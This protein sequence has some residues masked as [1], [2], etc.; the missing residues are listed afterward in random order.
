M[1]T[2]NMVLPPLLMA[3]SSSRVGYAQHSTINRYEETTTPQL[4]ELLALHQSL[5]EIPSISGY[6]GEVGRYLQN[7]LEQRGYDV[8]A[9]PVKGSRGNDDRHNIFAYL[10]DCNQDGGARRLSGTAGRVLGC[11]GSSSARL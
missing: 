3:F 4:L 1:N 11:V 2:W 10:G 8:Y 6:E 9:Q 7:C 5:V